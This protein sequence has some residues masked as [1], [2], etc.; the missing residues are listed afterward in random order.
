M[1]RA[2]RIKIWV[3]ICLLALAVFGGLYFYYVWYLNHTTLN[4]SFRGQTVTFQDLRMI[5]PILAVPLI[6]L[7]GAVSLSDLSRPQQV[8]SA[9]FRSLILVALALALAR[10]VRTEKRSVVCTVFLVDTSAGVSDAQIA[11]ARRLIQRAI[12]EKGDNLVR[13][14]TFARRPR[15]V[16]IRKGN[17]GGIKRFKGSAAEATNIQAALQLAYGLYPGDTVKRMVI[18]SDGLETSGD[19]LSE[20]YRA[21]EVG[22]KIHHWSFE[23]APNDEVLVK[24]VKLPEKVEIGKRFDVTVDVYSNHSTE[25]RFYLKH[26]TSPDDMY[27]NEL[28]SSK[29]VQLKPGLNVVKFPTIVHEPGLVAYTVEMRLPK[30]A[31]GGGDGKKPIGEESEEKTE[32]GTEG[33]DGDDKELPRE[34]SVAGED[35]TSKE[36]KAPASEQRVV[37]DNVKENNRGVAIMTIR[38]KPRILVVEGGRRGHLDKFLNALRQEDFRVELRG[39][40]GVP[41]SPWGLKKF[42]CV[43]QSDVMVSAMGLSQMAAIDRY[44]KQFGGCYIMAGGENSFGS[45]GYQGSRIERI[46]PVRMDTERRRRTPYI[47]LVLVID[48]SGSMSGQ[49]IEL[50]KEA[51]KAS[52]EVLASNDLIGVIAHDTRAIP[53]VNLQRAANRLRIFSSIS[54]LTAGGG[55]A[56]Y[57]AIK[58]AYDWLQTAR[59]KVKHVIVLSDGYSSRDGLFETVE[60]MRERG[61]T[62]STVGIGGSV[63][64]SLLQGIKDRGGGRY[65]HTND[66]NNIPKLFV[67]ETREVA[68]PS[69]Q[70]GA[71]TAVLAK[72]ADFLKN[73]GIT[74]VRYFR[75]Y[76]PTKPKPRAELFLS[77]NPTGDPL[78]AK[79]KWGLGNTIA[80]TSDVKG[81]WTADW[82]EQSYGGYR[83]FW[84]Q[85]IRSSMRARSFQEFPMETEVREGRIHVTVDAIDRDDKFINDLNA[86]IEVYDW[87]RPHQKRTLK[88]EQTA[89]GRYQGLFS[90]DRYG[91]YVIQGRHKA[92]Y[93]V[94]GKDGQTKT[95]YKTIA[96]SFGSVTLSYP[97]EY[98]EMQPPQEECLKNPDACTGL[99]RLDKLSTISGGS[100]L[101]PGY[102]KRNRKARK[103]SFIKAV[104]DEE[105]ESVSYVRQLWPYLI[106][107]IL[108]LLLLDVFLRRVRLFGYRP[109]QTR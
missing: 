65:Y 75:G 49:R 16:P 11:E 93:E 46:L 92:P 47:A 27:W 105:G 102:L 82:L 39:K 29:T 104:F 28:Q 90:M 32:V 71:Y 109:L 12:D 81:G 20:A 101:D 80:F 91:A 10:P 67:K 86:E 98:L 78:L 69:I 43:V 38:D 41:S 103:R 89:A 57:P 108:G 45:G 50:A 17:L 23:A 88:L 79:W 7:V 66:P 99:N 37:R 31:V 14:I 33:E 58:M 1:H 30:V 63:D 52:T 9:F 48:R 106:W 34:D 74:S 35:T 94:E 100:G 44:V 59:A 70:E 55:T 107:L 56:I 51:A 21:S 84:A 15:L 68:R 77:V 76:N 62:V 61:I 95:N 3:L 25:A 8:L 22:I 97:R 4:V 40:H 85:L 54:S 42:H 96:E 64:T 73:T 18:F 13:V 6:W 24:E 2:T 5:F 26:G 53:I 60:E 87:E 72:N 19:A 83:K 36:G